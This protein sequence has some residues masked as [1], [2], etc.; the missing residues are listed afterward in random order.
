MT[1]LRCDLKTADLIQTV[2]IR[3]DKCVLRSKSV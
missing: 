2:G 1:V 3:A